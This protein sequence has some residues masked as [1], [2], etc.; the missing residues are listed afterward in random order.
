[1]V[2][3]SL[4]TLPQFLLYRLLWQEVMSCDISEHT[5]ICFEIRIGNRPTSEWKRIL[6]ESWLEARPYAG[7]RLNKLHGADIDRIVANFHP[8]TAATTIHS[9]T[10]IPKQA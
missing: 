1:M 5:S 8:A 9:K 3:Y 7:L 10:F 6:P 4:K 2:S